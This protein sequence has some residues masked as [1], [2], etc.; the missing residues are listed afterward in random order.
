[1]SNEVDQLAETDQALGI[2]RAGCLHE[3]LQKG[4]VLAVLVVEVI[5]V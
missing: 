5:L 2:G 1:V 3:E 4:L